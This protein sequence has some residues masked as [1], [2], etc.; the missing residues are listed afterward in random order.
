MARVARSRGGRD[1]ARSARRRPPGL[2]GR[3]ARETPWLQGP[4]ARTEPPEQRRIQRSARAGQ[5]I[6]DAGTAQLG[7]VAATPCL[8]RIEV[9][10][11]G[12]RAMRKNF[13][14]RLD[15]AKR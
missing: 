7:H 1:A 5:L 4:P 2:R 11:A 6:V 15:I 12:G 14:T 8:D 9:R 13:F 10:P 3:S